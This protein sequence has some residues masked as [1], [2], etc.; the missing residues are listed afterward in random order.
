M[1]SLR[2]DR[3]C[4]PHLGEEASPLRDSAGIKPDFALTNRCILSTMNL[5]APGISELFARPGSGDGFRRRRGLAE[6]S[7]TTLHRAASS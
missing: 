1:N 4:S 3:T 6:A 7:S 5:D 2:G